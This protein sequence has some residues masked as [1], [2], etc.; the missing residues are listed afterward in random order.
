MA[1]AEQELQQ[2]GFVRTAKDLF[3]GAAGGVA[4]VLLG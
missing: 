1:E 2:G 3:A 4:Q